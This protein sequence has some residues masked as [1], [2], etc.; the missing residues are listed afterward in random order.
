MC[1]LRLT[2]NQCEYADAHRLPQ[3][4]EQTLPNHLNHPVLAVELQ[5][6]L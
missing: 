2:R 6:L 3:S 4:N 5:K 1:L